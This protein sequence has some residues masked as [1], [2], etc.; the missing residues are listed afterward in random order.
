[1][2]KNATRAQFAEIFANS[3]PEGALTSIND[4]EDGAIPDVPMT[5]LC[6]SHVYKLYRAGILAGGDARGTFSPN[7]Y[8]TRQECATIVARMAESNS[9]VSFT[10]G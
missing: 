4:V 8:I 7:S 1:M 2:S 3:L 6:A 5:E 9:R 10:L